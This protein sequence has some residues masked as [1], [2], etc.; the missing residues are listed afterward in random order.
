MIQ[1][2]DYVCAE[3]PGDALKETNGT[4]LAGGTDIVPLMKCEVK[5]I[6]RLVNIN[7]IRELRQFTLDEEEVFI[8]AM[9][10]LTELCTHEAIAE[11]YPALSFAARCVASPQ[12]RNAGTIGGNIMQDRRC[13]YFNQSAV[14]RSSIETCYKTG[15]SI[16]HQAPASSVC[17]AIYYSDVA[18]A[19]YALDAQVV[20]Y[21]ANGLSTA[22]IAQVIEKH[23]RINGT[24]ENEHMLITGFRLPNTGKGRSLFIKE[25]IR[26]A[27]DFPIFNA[28]IAI[29]GDNIRLA[30]GAISGTPVELTDTEAFI[31][32]NRHQLS[33]MENELKE[34]VMKE[35]MEKAVL[36][37]EGTIS[38]QVKKKAMHSIL[39]LIEQFSRGG[40]GNLLI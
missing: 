33:G 8:G 17:R 12:I 28:A 19:L 3:S 9:V 38:V 23:S 32:Q 22:P 27:I 25:S 1:R 13:F 15:G 24:F 21:D 36:I 37:R 2:F 16:C 35:I 29:V 30:A 6:E 39:A 14:W 40:Y 34:L 20:L 5:H 31:T 11:L 7:E 18:T 26:D 10:T 4:F